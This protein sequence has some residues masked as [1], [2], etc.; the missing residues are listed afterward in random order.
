MEL[1]D[2]I[3]EYKNRFHL[4]NVQIAERF[5]VTPNTV[6]RWLR[7]EVKSL[8]D[9]TAYN[10]SQVLGYDVQA[11]LSGKVI[12]LKRP[13]L[14]NVK[15]GYDLFL[16]EN[17][18][19]EEAISLEEYK[20]GDFFLRV[21]GDSM[22]NVGIADGGLVYVKQCSFVENGDIAVISFND[23]VTI[24]RFYKNTDGYE[25]KAENDLVENR[26]FSFA[27]AE[28]VSLKILGKVIFS[29]NYL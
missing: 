5:K 22:I 29:K 24:K 10:I 12:T 11:L 25:L 2:I 16:E 3:R 14:G 27:E 13:I 21:Q 9:D 8:Q 4:S 26:Y 1:R 20:Q 18:I 7:G 15:A 23:E 6:A 28:R 19:G 17:Y